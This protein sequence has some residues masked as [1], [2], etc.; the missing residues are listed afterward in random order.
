MPK[1]LAS[2]QVDCDSFWTLEKFWGLPETVRPRSLYAIALPRFLEL[3]RQCGVRATFFVIGRDLEDPASVAWLGEAAAEGH[4][5]ANHSMRHPFGFASLEPAQQI[6]EIE[7]A[8]AAIRTRLGVEPVG[9]RAPAYSV[10][11]SVL[12]ALRARGYLYDASVLPSL[13]NPLAPWF[14]WW[15]GRPRGLP[16]AD[17]GGWRVM[18][19]PRRPYYPDGPAVWR[20][21]AADGLVELPLAVT[22]LVRLPFYANAHLGS[23]FRIFRGA[24]ASLGAGPVN[25]LLHLI[26]LA[27]AEEIGAPL[28]RHP[29]ASRSLAH[30]QARCRAILEALAERFELVPAREVAASWHAARPAGVAGS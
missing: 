11:G 27:S 2:I 24:L 23:G 3:F 8:D 25:Y 20:R 15:R 4:E 10:S 7:E 30:K 17:L 13:C 1:P 26:E 6:R 16:P 21:G 14:L 29:H 18:F 12:E 19:A 5:I 28:W 9:F 22:P